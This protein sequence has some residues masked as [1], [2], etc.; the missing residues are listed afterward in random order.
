MM[1]KS[2]SVIAVLMLCYCCRP[3]F[4]MGH[5][6]RVTKDTQAKEGLQYTLTAELVNEKVVLVQIEVPNAGKLKELRSVSMTIGL[7]NGSP[8]LHAQLH[9]WPGKNGSVVASF[10]LSSE[11]AKRCSVD[12]QDSSTPTYVVYAVELKGYVTER[13]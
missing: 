4:A 9:T 13:K 8:E 2:I 6:V 3:V 11:L 5:L 1:K 7:G 10:Q 12:L